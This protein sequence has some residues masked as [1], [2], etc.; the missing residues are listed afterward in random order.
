MERYHQIEKES[1]IPFFDE[2]GYLRIGQADD[3]RANKIH[4]VAKEL[5]SNGIEVCQVDDEYASKHFPYLRLDQHYLMAKFDMHIFA[6]A[7]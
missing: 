2:V 7:A 5:R 6:T 4:A 1:G 3:E